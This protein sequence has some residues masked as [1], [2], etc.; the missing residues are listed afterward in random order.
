MAVA[1]LRDPRATMPA[2][3][4]QS[5]PR[6]RAG[7]PA[8]AVARPRPLGRGRAPAGAAGARR[9]AGAGGALPLPLGRAR[10]VAAVGKFGGLMDGGGRVRGQAWCHPLSCLPGPGAIGFRGRAPHQ[11]AETERAGTDSAAHHRHHPPRLPRGA[12]AAAKPKL[13]REAEPEEAWL[14][15]AEKE[16]KSPFKD[17]LAISAIL[18]LLV[19]FVI[20]GIAI[21]TGARAAAGRRARGPTGCGN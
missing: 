7:R 6:A 2:G 3:V 21:G 18:G 16:G 19:P 10:C 8:A 14:S 13:T 5:V 20:L 17:P 1:H 15:K 12:A 9:G 4:A 11:T